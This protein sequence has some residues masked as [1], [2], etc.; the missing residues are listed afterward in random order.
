MGSEKSSFDEKQKIIAESIDKQRMVAE[1]VIK[2]VDTLGLE[3]LKKVASGELVLE[4]ETSK[5]NP[6]V[7]SN[8]DV[9]NL[10]MVLATKRL[11]NLR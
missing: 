10:Y 1:S 4:N 2:H 9:R 11:R 3:D 5:E 6:D 8:D 7:M